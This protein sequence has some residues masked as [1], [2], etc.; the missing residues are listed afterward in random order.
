MAG[1]ARAG[2]PLPPG[3]LWGASTS[4]TQIE[5]AV[6]ADGRAASIWDVFASQPG[7]I[8]D[9]STPGTACDHYHR[10]P[11]DVALMRRAGM[12]AYRFSVAWPRVQ[13][14]GRGAVNGPGLDFY[15]HLT[16]A[17]L[18]A[19]IRPMPCL[20]HWDLPQAL[21]DRGG[22]MNRDIAGWFAD[23]AQV[24]AARLGDRVGDWFT[25]NEPSVSAILGHGMTLHAP[26][27]GGGADATLKALH[28]Q[29]LAQGDALAALRAIG[30]AFRLGT[31]LSLQPV[32]P[33]HPGEEHRAAAER[34]DALWNRVPLDGVLR[35]EVPGILADAMGRWILEGDL[36]RIRFPLDRIG[37]NYYSRLYIEARP[38][39]LV[40]AGFGPAPAGPRTDMGWP[41]EAHGLTET[42]EDL[43]D[44]Y[45]NPD[46]LITE[47]GI[48]CD[49]RADG[50]GRVDDRLRILY[51]EEHLAAVA[52]A[53]QKG[54][55]VGGYLAWSLL[56][57][58]E[59]QEGYRRRFGLVRV[60]YRTGRRTPKASFDWYRR[61]IAE[62]PA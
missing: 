40:D 18:E 22:W 39:G 43:R 51:L 47:N 15:D 34:W 26:G 23:Y 49:D 45:G 54:C 36:E 57:N 50:A 33:S 4:A 42:L 21:Q 24:V 5:G 17:L 35:G 46:V 2:V 60:D 31:I 9:G 44:N 61:R 8:A 28:H 7:A 1:P 12:R 37:V 53:I 38:G 32:R 55:R 19:G 58:W 48:A 56:D 13:P 6:D 14:A 62:T 11:A 27:L 25:L 52:Q 10:W 41:I 3:F 16:D 29:N 20:Y 59:W 30:P